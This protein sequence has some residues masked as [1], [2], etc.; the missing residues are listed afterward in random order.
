MRPRS[1]RPRILLVED[2]TTICDFLCEA[3]SKDYE[4]TCVSRAD[5]ALGVFTHQRIDV[6]LLDYYLVDGNG[7][8][9]AKR[10]DQ[11]EVPVVWMPG[12]PD[13]VNMLARTTHFTITKPFG[14]QKMLDA[15]AKAR[16]C[17]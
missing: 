8:D 12:D 13:A 7:Q 5:E 2:E 14:I 16:A 9:V 3:L 4:V 6:V 10:T 15:L 17:H 1:P 11:A